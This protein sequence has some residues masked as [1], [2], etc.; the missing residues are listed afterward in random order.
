MG[1]SMTGPP[2]MW[3]LEPATADRASHNAG[4]CG[5]PRPTRRRAKP[6]RGAGGPSRGAGS[7]WAGVTG[8][9]CRVGGGHG[10]RPRGG[11]QGGAT[12]GPN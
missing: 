6:S 1:K 10:G 7:G 5:E 4:G 11:D 8:V 9:P 12:A 2:R 3:P